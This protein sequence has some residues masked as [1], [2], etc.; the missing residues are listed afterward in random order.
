MSFDFSWFTTVPGLFI[1]GGVILLIVAL[2]I[3]LISNKKTKKEKANAEANGSVNGNTVQPVVGQ[4]EPI[5]MAPV[6]PEAAPV[7]VAPAAPVEVAPAM[8]EVAPVEVAP[9]PVEVAPAPVNVVPTVEP[10]AAPATPSIPSLET[11]PVIYGGASPAVGD[12]NVAP[13][14]THQIYGG[15]DP[16]QNTQTIPG[17]QAQPAPVNDANVQPVMETP[18]LGETQQITIPQIQQ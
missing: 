13:V 16:L 7:E 18:S 8:P 3:L 6:M 4:A 5:P 2:V 10:V 17:I 14:E 12:I 15:A 1:T 11:G 9:T